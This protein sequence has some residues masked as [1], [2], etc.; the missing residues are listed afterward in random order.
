MAHAAYQGNES[1][2]TMSRLN[3]TSKI[4]QTTRRRGAVHAV[5]FF[6]Q[7]RPFNSTYLPDQ[8]NGFPSL[9][10]VCTGDKLSKQEES[11]YFIPAFISETV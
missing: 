7:H 2:T 3:D 11:A 6:H 1:A 10:N 9:I 5:K 8:N 4:F